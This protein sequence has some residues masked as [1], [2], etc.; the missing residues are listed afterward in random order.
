MDVSQ[1]TPPPEPQT[2]ERRPSVFVPKEEEKK[3]EAV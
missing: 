3:A 2:N 1:K